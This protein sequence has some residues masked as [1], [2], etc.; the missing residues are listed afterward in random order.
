VL[1]DSD[2]DAEQGHVGVSKVDLR[3]DLVLLEALKLRFGAVNASYTPPTNNDQRNDY[4]AKA[5]HD[6]HSSCHFRSPFCL[7]VLGNG[8]LLFPSPSKESIS[9]AVFC[10]P[11][12]VP[13]KRMSNYLH[14]LFIPCLYARREAARTGA[15]QRREREGSATAAKPSF[16]VLREFVVAA[17]R[18]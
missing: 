8:A 3:L 4:Q 11:H 7:R 18:S 5:G 13:P 15:Y 6:L 2:S 12:P 9:L 14:R 1:E 16:A 10:R 17:K